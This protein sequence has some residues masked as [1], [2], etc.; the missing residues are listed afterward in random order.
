MEIEENTEKKEED[1]E[2]EEI[3]IEENLEDNK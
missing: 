1:I 2:E 3:K